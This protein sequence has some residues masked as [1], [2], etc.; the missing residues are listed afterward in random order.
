MLGGMEE[1]EYLNIQHSRGGLQIFIKKTWGNFQLSATL[2]AGEHL[3]N[4]SALDQT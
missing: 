3:F 4:I 1:N 2:S